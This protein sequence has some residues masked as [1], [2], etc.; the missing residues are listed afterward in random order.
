M[1]PVA[2]V[3]AVAPWPSDKEVLVIVRIVFFDSAINCWRT[4]DILLVPE[5]VHM[6]CW[7]E[8]RRFI[9]PL[10]C[11]DITPIGTIT[12]V[13]N[14]PFP[15][16]VSVIKVRTQAVFSRALSEN[17]R[18]HVRR[19]VRILGV[20]ARFCFHAVDEIKCIISAKGAPVKPIVG[21]PDI[22]HGVQG[23][24]G[25][26]CWVRVAHG[27][28]GQPAGIGITPDSNPAIRIYI[29]DDPV[30]G[31]PGIRRLVRIRIIEGAA[32]CTVHEVVAF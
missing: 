1:A 28:Q 16:F 15:H 25:S 21:F 19:I 7:H 32:W 27:S 13:F 31:I 17:P 26:Q 10:I 30:D 22:D 11:G 23:N 2:V 12:R 29:L 9:K 8:P 3:L 20:F 14:N 18:I 24:S 4:V 6:Q 5:A